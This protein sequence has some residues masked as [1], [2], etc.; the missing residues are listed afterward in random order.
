MAFVPHVLSD[1]VG[2][3]SCDMF[4]C[5]ELLL[6][7]QDRLCKTHVYNHSAKP[8]V[9]KSKFFLWVCP[10]SGLFFWRCDVCPSRWRVPATP[11]DHRWFRSWCALDA[12][13]IRYLLVIGILIFRY[14]AKIDDH[15]GKQHHEWSK[16][17]GTST[18]WE[19]LPT[20]CF[21]TGPWITT[22]NIHMFSI[23][24]LIDQW[25]SFSY[26]AY[27]LISGPETR[28]LQGIAQWD[29]SH[30]PRPWHCHDSP[31]R[32]NRPQ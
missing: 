28:T 8:C 18:D 12:A 15:C 31:W 29:P 16:G 10:F 14:R 11:S 26:I 2:L 5:E 13:I 9:W 20:R 7:N 3:I 4:G 1:G 21:E 22:Y 6:M 19:R 30:R 25:F 32:S 17:G 27:S 24:S 23:S